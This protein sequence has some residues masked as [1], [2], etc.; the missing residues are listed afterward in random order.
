M[1]NNKQIIE[2]SLRLKLGPKVFVE[3]NSQNK[4]DY[5]DLYEIKRPVLRFDESSSRWI[6]IGLALDE[7]GFFEKVTSEDECDYSIMCFDDNLKPVKMYFRKL[8]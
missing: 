5:L 3:Y 4:E 1:S 2:N 8:N 6:N 7:S